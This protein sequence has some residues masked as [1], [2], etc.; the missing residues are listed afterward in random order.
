LLTPLGG[1]GASAVCSV[2]SLLLKTPG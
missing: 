2:T 1:R